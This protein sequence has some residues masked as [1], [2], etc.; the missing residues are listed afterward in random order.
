L[1]REEGIGKWLEPYDLAEPGGLGRY[2]PGH[3]P[4]LGGSS[5]GGA[6]RVETPVGGNPVEPGAE[7]GASLKPSEALP[8]PLRSGRLSPRSPQR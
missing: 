6:T 5:A 2:N 3:V 4:L 8:A 7:R 1:R